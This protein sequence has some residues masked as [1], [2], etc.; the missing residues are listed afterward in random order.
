MGHC[1]AFEGRGVKSLKNPFK[2]AG[3]TSA[4]T[5]IAHVYLYILYLFVNI[6][7]LKATILGRTKVCW[8]IYHQDSAQVRIKEEH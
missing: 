1:S 4:R 7:V 2:L 3:C 5:L 8:L 6:L